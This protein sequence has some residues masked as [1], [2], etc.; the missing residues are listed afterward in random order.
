MCD[1]VCE[2]APQEQ[3]GSEAW[4][5]RTRLAAHWPWPVLKRF[6]VD[7]KRWRRS[8]PG[9]AVEGSTINEQFTTSEAAHSSVHFCH[10]DTSSCCGSSSHTGRPDVNLSLLDANMIGWQWPRFAMLCWITQHALRVDAVASKRHH[11]NDT[12]HI[13]HIICC[14]NTF[15]CKSTWERLSSL[16]LHKT[17]Y[18]V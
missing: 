13:V 8:N 12:K 18:T 5:Q 15:Y 2:V 17:Q 7:D 14:Q 1:V 10:G 9:G 11:A 6:N 3:D 4:F 16:F